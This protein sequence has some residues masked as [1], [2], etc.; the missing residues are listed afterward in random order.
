MLAKAGG[1]TCA[2]M[3][4]P[5]HLLGEMK[6]GGQRETYNSRSKLPKM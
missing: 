5:Q 2:I 1:L 6:S 4:T 3:T